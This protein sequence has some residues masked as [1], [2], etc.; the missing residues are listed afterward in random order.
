[1]RPSFE[2]MRD[3]A[4]DS[5][6]QSSCWIC[7]AVFAIVVVAAV[8]AIILPAIDAAKDAAKSRPKACAG[9]VHAECVEMIRTLK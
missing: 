8:C 3:F 6:T 5:R 4:D 2:E 7:K 9:L 1:M